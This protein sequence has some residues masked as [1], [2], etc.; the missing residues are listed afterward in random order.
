MVYVPLF[1]PPS[2]KA[3]A[4]PYPEPLSSL[5]ETLTDRPPAGAK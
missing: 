4:E 3:E 1:W 5:A 2:M